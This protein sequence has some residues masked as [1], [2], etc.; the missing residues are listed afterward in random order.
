MNNI[1][2]AKQLDNYIAALELK[3][4]SQQLELKQTIKEK[5]EALKP[6]NLLKNAWEH[7]VSSPEIKDNVI[8][9]SIGLAAGFVSKKIL[10][11]NTRNPIKRLLGSL[12]Q[13]GITN[14]VAHNP[15]PIKNLGINLFKMIVRKKNRK[16]EHAAN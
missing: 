13:F 1:T 6:A 3:K 10:V 4:A 9:N 5:V 16:G 14:L 7:V 12:A 11:G 2:T 15:G 8:D